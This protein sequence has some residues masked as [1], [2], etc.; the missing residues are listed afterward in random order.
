MTFTAQQLNNKVAFQ[1]STQVQDSIGDVSYEWATF[2]ESFAKVEPL[3]GR[4]Y[5][6]A[7]SGV[8][9]SQAKV[10][11]RWFDGLTQ[12]DRV[13]IRGQAWDITSIQNIK[14][15]NREMLLYI[16]RNRLADG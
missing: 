1:R 5:F 7:Q 13:V 2:R 14:Y 9:E 11:C 12:T 10:T 8:G 6:A 3:V 16:K 15:G 4:E